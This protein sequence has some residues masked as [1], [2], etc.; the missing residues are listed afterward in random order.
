MLSSE[1]VSLLVS[2]ISDKLLNW[3]SQNRWK[4]AH[5]PRKISLDFG[6]SPGHVTFGFGLGLGLGWGYGYG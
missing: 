3:F 4:V 1:L 2:R 6:G 5:G